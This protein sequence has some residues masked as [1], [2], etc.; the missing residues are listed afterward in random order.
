MPLFWALK[1]MLP[2][3]IDHGMRSV[4]FTQTV[5]DDG[6]GAKHSTGLA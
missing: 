5:M 2:A 6:G 1:V 4:K 3:K